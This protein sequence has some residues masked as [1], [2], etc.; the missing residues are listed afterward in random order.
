MHKAKN[1]IKLQRGYQPWGP[2]ASFPSATLHAGSPWKEKSFKK[3]PAP[4]AP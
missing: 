3:I 2:L 1:K 4:T